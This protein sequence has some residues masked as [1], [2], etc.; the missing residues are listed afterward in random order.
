[1][2]SCLKTQIW[3]SIFYLILNYVY[4]VINNQHN[5]ELS[6]I[7]QLSFQQQVLFFN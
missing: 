3:A 6:V 1:M 7:W 2:F 4:L 5:F